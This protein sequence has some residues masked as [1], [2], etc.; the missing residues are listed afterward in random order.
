MA[1]RVTSSIICGDNTNSTNGITLSISDEGD[2][3]SFGAEHRG[4]LG[5]GNETSIFPPKRIEF[6]ESIKS[7]QCSWGHVICLN[8]FGEVLRYINCGF[9]IV[10]YFSVDFMYGFVNS[11]EN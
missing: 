11:I 10:E 8:A 2:V 4:A 1:H 7:I 3:Y 9:I 6:L 5:Q